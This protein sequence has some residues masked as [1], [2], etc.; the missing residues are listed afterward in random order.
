MRYAMVIEKPES[1]CSAD[2]PDS[3]DCVAAGAAGTEG[4]AEIRDAMA[5]HLE[6]LREEGLPIPQPSGRVDYV[7]VA[8]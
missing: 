1:D 2:V 5:F 6:G 4:E 7:E 3:P 8:V